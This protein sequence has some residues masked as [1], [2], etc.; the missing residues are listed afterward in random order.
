MEIIVN[1]S[2]SRKLINH[3]IIEVI[4]KYR[5]II[6]ITLKDEDSFEISFEG[7]V[8]NVCAE[9]ANNLIKYLFKK[10]GILNNNVHLFQ[11]NKP[12]F[13]KDIWTEFYEFIE[14]KDDN[15]INFNKIVTQ[16]I[17]NSFKFSQKDQELL[18]FLKVIKH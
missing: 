6:K 7:K 14:L 2:L 3:W 5:K 15:L 16:D 13:I 18:H 4:K 1:S 12:N 8:G 10:K 17:K 11:I 9:N